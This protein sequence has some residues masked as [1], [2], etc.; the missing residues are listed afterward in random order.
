[1]KILLQAIRGFFNKGNKNVIKVLSLA[2][3]L[4]IGIV[5]ISKNYFETSYENFY[6]DNE[7]IYL[8]SSVVN[9]PQ[10][11]TKFFDQVSG[12]IAPGFQ[13]YVP[14]EIGRAHV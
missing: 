12:A 9:R 8:I 13:D 10:E 3:A 7:R 6:P 14:G 11:D 2:A 5:L 1:M 4:A